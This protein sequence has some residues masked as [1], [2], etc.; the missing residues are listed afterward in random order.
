VAE[1]ARKISKYFI[2]YFIRRS[3][4][5]EARWGWKAIFVKAEAYHLAFG[6]G[7]CTLVP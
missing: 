6:R 1:K 3:S 5:L 4:A 7:Y 2:F